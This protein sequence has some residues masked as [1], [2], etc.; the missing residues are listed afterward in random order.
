MKSF[1]Q[2]TLSIFLSFKSLAYLVK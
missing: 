2:F 1:C